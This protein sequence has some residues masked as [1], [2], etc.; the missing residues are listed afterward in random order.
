MKSIKLLSVL[1][2]FFTVVLFQSCGDDPC[3]GVVCLNDGSVLMVLVIV[4]LDILG[5]IVRY[6]VVQI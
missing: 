4:Q 3:D 5:Q 2:L 6:I 1:A